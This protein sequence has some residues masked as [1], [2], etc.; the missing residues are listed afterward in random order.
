MARLVKARTCSIALEHRQCVSIVAPR[1]LNDS[2]QAEPD[3]ANV[4]DLCGL[5]SVYNDDYRLLLTEA[6]NV[7]E[8]S[9]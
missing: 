3:S 9:G 4:S 8:L 5:F 1:H 6:P 2:A 7:A